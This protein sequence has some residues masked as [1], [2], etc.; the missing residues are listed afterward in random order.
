V[1][2]RNV[3]SRTAAVGKNTVQRSNVVVHSRNGA[4]VMEFPGDHSGL[5]FAARITLAHFSVSSAMS[6]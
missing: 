6:R 4:A 2:F 1:A 3:G 5:M